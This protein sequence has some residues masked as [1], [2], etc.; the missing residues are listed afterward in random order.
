[1]TKHLEI[2][3]CG[4]GGQGVVL[5]GQLLGRAAVYDGLN[6]VQT[7]SYGAEAR[8]SNAKSEVIISDGKIGFPL[9]RHCDVLVAMSQQSLDLSIKDLKTDGVLVVDEGLVERV[10]EDLKAK[11][12]RVAATKTAEDI[13]KSKLYTNIIMLGAVAKITKLVTANSMEKAIVEGLSENKREVNINA[14]RKGLEL[15]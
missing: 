15:A 6:V 12:F 7:Q 5:A 2:R 4:L 8:G 11:V 1:V 14:F 10:P 13:F 9:V 3:I